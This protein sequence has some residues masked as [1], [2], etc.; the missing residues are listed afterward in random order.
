MTLNQIISVCA[1]A[2]MHEMRVD[3]TLTEP[4]ADINGWS[5]I[6]WAPHGAVTI[7]W[8]HENNHAGT[9]RER[10]SLAKSLL[11]NA[12][13]SLTLMITQMQGHVPY[14]TED[15]VEDVID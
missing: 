8:T 10:I 11:E 12:A 15:K 14:K 1:R 7:A 2:V 6:L 3:Y 13:D 5:A 4:I 9:E